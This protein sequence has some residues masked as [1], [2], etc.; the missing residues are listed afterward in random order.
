MQRSISDPQGAH[1][2]PGLGAAHNGP[3][4]AEAWWWLVIPVL[5]AAA[6]LLAYWYAPDYYRTHILPEGT[7]YIEISHFVLPFT[8]FLICLGLMRQPRVK[9]DGWLRAAVVVFALACLY[10]AGEEYSWGQWLFYWSTPERWAEMNRQNETNLHNT[11]YLFNQFPQTLLYTAILVG[12]FILPLWGWARREL[13][14]LVPLVGY[15]VPPAAILPVSISALTFKQIDRL[16]KSRIV[17]DILE[18]PSEATETFY[19]MFILFY[20]IMLRQ[21]IKQDTQF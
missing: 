15:L 11:H 19:Y 9:A 8:G 3:G 7:G 1:L 2:S 21:K 14:R 12:G 13:A 4:W 6:I 10:I 5:T 16:Q 17:T 20:L 18:R